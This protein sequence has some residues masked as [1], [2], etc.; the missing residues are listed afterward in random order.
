VLVN[1]EVKPIQKAS[2]FGKNVY[3]LKIYTSDG[4]I[5]IVFEFCEL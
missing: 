1:Y 5:K 2:V 3:M 4:F